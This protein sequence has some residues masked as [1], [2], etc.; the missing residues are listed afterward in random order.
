MPCSLKGRLFLEDEKHLGPVLDKASKKKG[1]LGAASI[2]CLSLDPS[3]Q[4]W[5]LIA[6]RALIA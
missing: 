4:P 1:A 5:T 6:S 2:R 3:I